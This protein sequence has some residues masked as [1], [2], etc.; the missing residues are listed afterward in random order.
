M[1]ILKF[2][3]Y[4]R[5]GVGNVIGKSLN[6]YQANTLVGLRDGFLTFLARYV[7]PPTPPLICIRNES[8]GLC[9]LYNDY[10]DCSNYRSYTG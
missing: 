3:S 6:A 1:H 4:I 8:G 7:R 2:L 9:Y 10:S 5:G